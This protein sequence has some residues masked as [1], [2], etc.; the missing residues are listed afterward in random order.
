[1]TRWI[2]KI[3]YKSFHRA[4]TC[5][6]A[7]SPVSPAFKGSEKCPRAART[8]SDVPGPGGI[9]NV[10]FIGNAL[11]FRSYSEYW[12]VFLF[13]IYCSTAVLLVCSILFM[14]S[15]SN[16]C[17]C[18]FIVISSYWVLANWTIPVNNNAVNI[19]AIRHSHL[20]MYKCKIERCLSLRQLHF[21]E[22]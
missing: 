18:L 20:Q 3:Y 6:Y 2:C 11:Q 19:I 22:K 14:K 17:V 21:R 5:Q 15:I 13:E 8:L 9:Y 1:M 10:P 16:F 4:L 7:T 12:T